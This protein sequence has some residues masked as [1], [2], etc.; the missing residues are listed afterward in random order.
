MLTSADYYLF[1]MLL[2]MGH[3]INTVEINTIQIHITE[4][5]TYMHNIY[6]IN[7]KLNRLHHVI[8]IFYQQCEFTVFIYLFIYL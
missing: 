4:N 8:F 2:F 7:N 6:F 3:F 5:Y 1:I